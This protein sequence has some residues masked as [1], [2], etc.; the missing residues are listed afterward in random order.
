MNIDILGYVAGLMVVFSLLPQVLKSWRTKSTADIS[1]ARYV[2][3]V[4]GLVL[5]VIYA[6]LI[7]NKPVAVMNG[8]GLVF[9]SSILYLK[10]RYG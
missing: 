9:A 3:Y 1:L 7:Q 8:V 2:I 5:W 4:A 10:L 6:V